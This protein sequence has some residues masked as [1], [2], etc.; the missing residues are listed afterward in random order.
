MK[1]SVNKSE[2]IRTND[3]IFGNKIQKVNCSV[4]FYYYSFYSYRSMSHA[5]V[6]NVPKTFNFYTFTK[7][8]TKTILLLLKLR[9][10]GKTHKDLLYNKNIYKNWSNLILSYS[11][12]YISYLYIH[13]IVAT[14]SKFLILLIVLFFAQ[15]EQFQ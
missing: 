9:T 13:I 11:Q 6:I 8:K 12:R 5:I 7:F 3:D 14:F 1:C 10:R 4:T 15:K 2:N